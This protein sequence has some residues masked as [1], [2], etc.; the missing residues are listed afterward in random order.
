[1]PLPERIATSAGAFVGSESS[2]RFQAPSRRHC[3]PSTMCSRRSLFDFE[4]RVET[5]FMDMTYRSA[6]GPMF[7]PGRTRRRA[8]KGVS[9]VS[10]GAAARNRV[11]PQAVR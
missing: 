9:A 3:S 2:S 10:L 4:R 6:Q 8:R 11:A 7:N 1:M 5:P